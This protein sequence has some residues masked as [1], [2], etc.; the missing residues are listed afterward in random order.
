MDTERG[1]RRR[2]EPNNQQE[3][4]YSPGGWY[5]VVWFTSVLPRRPSNRVP[6]EADEEDEEALFDGAMID[7]AN[8][9]DRRF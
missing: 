6:T 1:R 5:L 2:A 7:S 8:D 9:M 3:E 4:S